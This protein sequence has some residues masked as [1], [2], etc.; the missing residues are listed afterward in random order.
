MSMTLKIRFVSIAQTS[1]AYAS[2]AWESVP[3]RGFDPSSIDFNCGCL[4][5]K[6]EVLAWCDKD[7]EKISEID[8]S[9]G[10]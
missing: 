4:S 1:L 3:V 7:K 5:L 9:T 10:F 2:N 8:R 6:R